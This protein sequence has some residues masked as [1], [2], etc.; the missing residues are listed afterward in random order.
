MQ[1]G[2]QQLPGSSG[3][4]GKPLPASAAPLTDPKSIVCE[5]FR[6]ERWVRQCLYRVAHALQAGARP[7]MALLLVLGRVRC[8]SPSHTL[9]PS[10]HPPSHLNCSFTPSRCS[11]DCG[12]EEGSHLFN[13]YFSPSCVINGAFPGQVSGG[14]RP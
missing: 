4:T 10:P 8:G 7:K 11:M 9:S 12:I 13:E 6:A 2:A 1:K 5:V 3:P 14:M